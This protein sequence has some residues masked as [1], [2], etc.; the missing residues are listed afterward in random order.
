MTKKRKERQPFVPILPEYTKFIPHYVI[1]KY[2]SAKRPRLSEIKIECDFTVDGEVWV[3]LLQD[4]WFQIFELLEL[5][6]LVRLSAVC[7]G[8]KEKVNS[9]QQKYKQLCI[10]K[11]K[12]A[13]YL[14]VFATILL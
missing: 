8:M 1:E 11:Y 3:R 5:R 7:K 9:F 14:Q 10:E 12:L 2:T 13:E 4:V 6:M